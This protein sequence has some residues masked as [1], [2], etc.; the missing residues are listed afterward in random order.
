MINFVN[1]STHQ[2]IFHLDFRFNEGDAFHKAVVR[3]SNFPHG[4]WGE[5]ERSDNPLHRGNPFKI[6]IKV[7]GDRFNVSNVTY[8]KW[9][10]L[11][12]IGIRM[13]H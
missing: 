4:H 2:C 8:K 12:M 10:S 9:F 5:E 3:N 7:F 13:F 6:Q 1:K 11:K